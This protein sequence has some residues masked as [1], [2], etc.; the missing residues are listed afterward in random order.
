M[1]TNASVPLKQITQCSE[2]LVLGPSNIWTSSTVAVSSYLLPVFCYRREIFS[3]S[4]VKRQVSLVFSLTSNNER[5]H[6]ELSDNRKLEVYS[7]K[8]SCIFSSCRNGKGL[9]LNFFPLCSNFGITVCTLRAYVI[10]ITVASVDP[11][12]LASIFWHNTPS[13]WKNLNV[14]QFSKQIKLYLFSEQFFSTMK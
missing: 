3:G 14:Y 4:L 1:P 6:S 11:H 10:Q 9:P 2:I 13:Y 8:L 5:I 7:D 12:P